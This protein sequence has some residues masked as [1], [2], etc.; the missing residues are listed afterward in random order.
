MTTIEPALAFDR[1]PQPGESARR[2]DIYGRLHVASDHISKAVVNQYYGAIIS[3][4]PKRYERFDGSDQSNGVSERN[5]Y[6]NHR[7]ELP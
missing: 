1:E 6:R 2:Y 5:G 7:Q 4:P 3:K